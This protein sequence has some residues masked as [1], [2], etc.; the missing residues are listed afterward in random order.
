MEYSKYKEI[1]DQ[2]FVL[3]DVTS[4]VKGLVKDNTSFKRLTTP[5]NIKPFIDRLQSHYLISIN[6]KF[7]DALEAIVKQYLIEKGVSFLDRNFVPQ[8]D[9]DQIFQFNNKIFLIEQKIRD[10]HDS[11]KKRG[12]VNNYLTKKQ[13]IKEKSQECICCSWFIDPDFTKNKNY[14]LTEIPS[15]ELYYGKEIEYF[16]KEKVFHDNKCDGFF[17]E[18]LNNIIKYKNSFSP[19][20]TT[21]LYIDY[22]DFSITELFRLLQSKS[23]HQEIAQVFFNGHIPFKEISQYVEEGRTVPCKK[24]FQILLKE[25]IKNE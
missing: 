23:Y 6:I 22:R 14:Y 17:Q 12:Q 20:Q 16:F 11:S 21:S 10:D 13:V 24:D 5:F 18:L 3:S 15:D 19:F 25:C 1:F 2:Y 4:F 9:C 7:G 8:H